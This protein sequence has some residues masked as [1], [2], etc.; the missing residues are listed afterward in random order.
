MR[1]RRETINKPREKQ[2][3]KNKKKGGGKGEGQKTP[4]R[5]R[6]SHVTWPEPVS[7]AVLIEAGDDG[8]RHGY[9]FRWPSLPVSDR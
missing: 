4:G 8:P 5:V 6:A 1:E 3:E 7:G 2:E 9:R